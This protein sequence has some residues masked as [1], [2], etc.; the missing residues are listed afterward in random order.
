VHQIGHLCHKNLPRPTTRPTIESYPLEVF[1]PRWMHIAPPCL[2]LLPRL[3]FSCTCCRRQHMS[4]KTKG[5]EVEEKCILLTPGRRSKHRHFQQPVFFF[6]AQ[7]DQ[8]QWDY[9][10]IAI[11]HWRSKVC[12]RDRGTPESSLRIDWSNHSL[13]FPYASIRRYRPPK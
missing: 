3:A 9:V 6:S 4:G 12:M 5:Q 1:A 10:W 8:T 7:I 11:W 2:H 13:S